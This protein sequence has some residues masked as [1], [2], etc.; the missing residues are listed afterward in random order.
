MIEQLSDQ[1]KR[2]YLVVVFTG[3]EA[4]KLGF[5]FCVPGCVDWYVKAFK[6]HATTN[7]LGSDRLVSTRRELLPKHVGLSFPLSSIQ[8]RVR[9]QH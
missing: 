2:I 5:E 4:E 6:G 7:G 9:R 3:R 1:A 8:V